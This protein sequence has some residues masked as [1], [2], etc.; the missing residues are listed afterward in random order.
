[1]SLKVSEVAAIARVTVRTLHHYDRLGL[2]APRARS[3][4]GYRLYAPQDLERLQQVL[5]FRELGFPLREV[6]RIMTDR[7][8][9]QTAALAAQRSLLMKKMEQLG[10]IVDAV[11]R[12]IAA[13]A[14]GRHD[15]DTKQMFA[16][17]RGF[18]PYEYEAEVE[19]RWGATDARREA[20]RRTAKYTVE[21]WKDIKA[22]AAKITRDLADR[23]DA[24]TP[25]ADRAVMDVAERHRQ[26]IDRWYYPCSRAMHVGLGNMYVADPRFAE[27]YEKVR[28]GLAAYMRDAIAA[29]AKRA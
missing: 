1:V 7:R 16:G 23:F 12:A 10:A 5:F 2:V 28:T 29:N 18:E 19:R 17:V 26:H 14:A 22:E 24:G 13:S 6:R 27:N 15:M 25:P 4:A 21:Q 9:D 20:G 8:F 11:D 3:R